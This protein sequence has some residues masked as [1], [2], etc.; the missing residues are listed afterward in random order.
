MWK[1]YW[2]TGLQ[3]NK[4]VENVILYEKTLFSFGFASQV[5][6]AGRYKECKRTQGVSTTELVGR[7]LLSTK[8]HFAKNEDFKNNKTLGKAPPLY[9]IFLVQAVP[10]YFPGTAQLQSVSFVMCG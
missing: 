7:M 10:H 9:P 6:A 1:N 5:K 4:M 8:D 2:A 3:K